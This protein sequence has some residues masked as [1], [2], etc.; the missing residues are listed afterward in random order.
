M[1]QAASFKLHSALHAHNKSFMIS[2][3]CT[4]TLADLQVC[5]SPKAKYVKYDEVT[6]SMPILQPAEWIAST[7]V[8]QY[9]RSAKW[10]TD[11]PKYHLHIRCSP[12]EYGT[13]HPQVLSVNMI[14][15]RTPQSPAFASIFPCFCL[16][17]FSA[18]LYCSIRVW[19]VLNPRIKESNKLFHCPED[20]RVQLAHP[21]FHSTDQ[22]ASE[23]IKWSYNKP[24]SETQ[25]SISDWISVGRISC[26]AV[27][28][29]PSG[30]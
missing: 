11:S 8:D 30:F 24:R 13:R 17:F 14:T 20:G 7:S 27:K 6:T 25:D 18:S 10:K 2:H 9:T 26:K 15:K 12:G 19:R 28:T 21:S 4:V 16:S 29:L 23:L 22:P 5:P 1:P 3:T